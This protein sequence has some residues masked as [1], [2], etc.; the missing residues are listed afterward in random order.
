LADGRPAAAFFSCR[1][2]LLREVDFPFYGDRDDFFDRAAPPRD[3]ESDDDDKCDDG[4]AAADAFHASATAA[5]RTCLH[6]SD[7]GEGTAAAAAA[8]K[9]EEGAREGEETFVACWDREGGIAE[10]MESSDG[11]GRPPRPPLECKN[12]APHPRWNPKSR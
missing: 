8:A 1:S 7:S 2:A 10:R 3:G 11:W 5:R 6:S 4:A 9:A 12:A